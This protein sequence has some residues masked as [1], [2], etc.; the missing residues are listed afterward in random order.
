MDNLSVHIRYGVLSEAVL[1]T[2]PAYSFLCGGV[3]LGS[4]PDVKNPYGTAHLAHIV[5]FI[6]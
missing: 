5:L 1:R 6:C 3:R 2:D 4:A